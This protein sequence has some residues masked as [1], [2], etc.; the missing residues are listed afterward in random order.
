MNFEFQKWATVRPGESAPL[1]PFIVVAH[2][3]DWHWAADHYRNWFRSQVSVPFA[4]GK[5]R[6]QAGGWSPFL[7]NAYG[8]IGYHFSEMPA[9]WEQ[10]R[11]LGMDLIIPY[12]W[13]RGGFDSQDPEYY[14]DLDLAACGASLI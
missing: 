5:W 13:S 4:D 8:K 10:E 12:G 1:A 2:G 14:P 11:R 6:E 9:L 3:N 7:K